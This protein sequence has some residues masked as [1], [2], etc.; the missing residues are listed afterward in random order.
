M[1]TDDIRHMARDHGLRVAGLKKAELI[2]QL[3]LHEGNFAC[4]ATAVDGDCDQ[5][6]C[7]WRQDCF[8][9]SKRKLR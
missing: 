1:R 3:Q 5:Q 9:E 8:R 4:F 6:A 7:L 2:H